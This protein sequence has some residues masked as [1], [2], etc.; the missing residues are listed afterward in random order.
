MAEN[1]GGKEMKNSGARKNGEGL[2]WLAPS[3]AAQKTKLK[4]FYILCEYCGL[5][6]HGKIT[7]YR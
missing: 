1:E 4:T 2:W 5:F 6:P 3:A 7:L